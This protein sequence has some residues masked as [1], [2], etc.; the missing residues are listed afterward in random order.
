MPDGFLFP[1][2]IGEIIGQPEDA[3]DRDQ[4]ESEEIGPNPRAGET[5]SEGFIRE[6]LE[7]DGPGGKEA[8]R[9]DKKKQGERQNGGHFGQG[10]KTKGQDAEKQVSPRHGVREFPKEKRRGK[11]AEGSGHIRGIEGSVRE[12]VGAKNEQQQRDKAAPRAEEF[13]GP[14]KDQRAQGGSQQGNHGPGLKKHRGRVI[15]QGVKKLIVLSVIEQFAP[16]FPR[17]LR[18]MRVIGQE[19]QGRPGLGENAIF[20]LQ[21]I[22]RLSPIQIARGYVADFIKGR[23]LPGGGR[24]RHDAVEQQKP[25][26]EDQL[27]VARDPGREVSSINRPLRRRVRF[28]EREGSSGFYPGS[29]SKDPPK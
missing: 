7:F 24:D 17:L 19:G 15:T 5:A 6:E 27:P 26:H 18:R 8:H 3:H 14:Q 13:A 4:M 10:Q 1:A 11:K 20:R 12:H 22:G 21:V 25:A 28:Q 2:I 29:A 23:R 16:R 9:Q